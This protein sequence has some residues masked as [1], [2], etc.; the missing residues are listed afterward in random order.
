MVDL[1]P[2]LEVLET[3]FIFSQHGP[4]TTYQL[5]REAKKLGIRLDADVLRSLHERGHLSPL[6]VITDQPQ[7]PPRATI[8]EP[9]ATDSTL[10]ELRVAQLAGRVLDPTVNPAA[11]DD[12][13]RFE[14]RRATDPRNWWNGLIYSRWQLLNADRIRRAAISLPATGSST[15]SVAEVDSLRRE[16]GQRERVLALTVTM[17][18]PRYL[19][20][21]ERGWLQ[22]R[23]LF[24]E[25][26][27]AWRDAYDPAAQLAQL[28]YLGVDLPAVFTLA[29]DL[30]FRAHRLDPSG[31]WSGLIRRA[32][33]GKWDSL[34]GDLAVAMNQRVAAEILLGFYEDLG[35]PMPDVPSEGVRG[36]HQLDERIS[37][38]EEPLDRVLMGLGV[39]PHPGATLL[40]EGETERRFVSRVFEHLGLDTAPDLV[41]VVTMNGV[42]KKLHLLATASVAPL[43]GQRRG[44]GYDLLRPP[45]H[46]IAAVDPEG[47]YKTREQ[48]E[49][50]RGAVVATISEVVQTQAPD[51]DLHHLDS[52]IEIRR[53]KAR[54]FEY[55]HFTDAELLDAITTVHTRPDARPS[56]P[57]LLELI[58]RARARGHDLKN[59]WWN[60]KYKPP[61]PDLADALW[62]A[63]RA[64]IDAAMDDAGEMPQVAE[65]VQDAYSRAQRF[66]RGSWSLGLTPARDPANDS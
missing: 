11:T 28:G 49:K 29:E 14:E 4:L 25:E 55:A 57:E 50:V 17:L 64:K 20:E 61:K 42:D 33:R 30:L 19:P 32:P 45:C 46:L 7:R 39:S 63:L 23:T 54:C 65:L 58:A 6:A 26:W 51:A 43:L 1:S 27:C 16:Q 38:R 40:L 21:I 66:S 52:L 35:G 37:A 59:V 41:Q 48:S 36:R 56:D 13:V 3:P 44:D 53:W 9:P 10:G 31:K 5:A 60:W 8:V 34:T 24:D 22:L 15:P 18:E 12:Q 2:A 47:Q 62:P